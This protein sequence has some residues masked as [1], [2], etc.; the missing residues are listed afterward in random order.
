MYMWKT[1]SSDSPIMIEEHIDEVLPL[2]FPLRLN[3]RS[4]IELTTGYKD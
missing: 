2:I 3:S 4:V 1:L